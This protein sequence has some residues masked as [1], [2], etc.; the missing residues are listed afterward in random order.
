MTRRFY[1]ENYTLDIDGGCLWATDREIRLRPKTFAVLSHLVQNAGRLVTK[2][3]L[4][5]AVWP[6]IVVTDESL[7]QCVS[8]ARRA[9]GRHGRTFIRTVPRRGYRFAVPVEM[10]ATE[11]PRIGEDL[12]QARSP[13]RCNLPM[14]AVLPLVD[15]SGDQREQYLADGITDDIIT[16]LS[17]FT[18]LSVI[19]R[20]SSFQYKDKIADIRKIGME[21][22]V[23]YLLEGSIR[24]AAG[25]LRV[26][27]RLVDATTGTDLW[28]E[29]YDRELRDVFAVQDDVVG[30]IVS[31]L[32][33]HVTKAE[34]ERALQK[35][36]A[37][38]QSYD[39]Y[40]R[41]A[42]V[43][44]THVSEHRLDL[45]YD[46]RKLLERSLDIDPD[47][48]RAHA[49]LSRTF[50]RAYVEPL[51]Q[52]YLDSSALSR[53]HDLAERAVRL[54][55]NLPFARSQLGWVLSFMRRHDEAIAEFEHA[56]SLNPS[57]TDFRF[58]LGLVFAGQSERAINVLRTSLRLDPFQTPV[59]LAYL[60]HAYFML[61]RLTEAV[62]P[63]RECVARIPRFRVARVWLAATY[64]HL[65][66]IDD[67][68]NEAAQV[69]AIEPLFSIARWQ[70]T[71]PYRY[72]GQAKHLFDALCKAGLPER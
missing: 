23:R 39:Y 42:A 72:D 33:A 63:L 48:S 57:Y 14:I 31:L 24:R 7:M 43:Y 20:N 56:V 52:D 30:T 54:D 53:A 15:L 70:R 41:G 50:T 38:W 47:Y 28:A 25:H 58:G 67:A 13:G 4:I 37:D 2:S 40:L 18:E 5:D 60:G 3:D 8:E 29:R 49:M 36:P 21:L 17:R 55:P 9:L 66:Q 46:A 16:E 65:D 59:R 61:D 71:A 10:P 1:F 34:S 62:S 69:L 68:R 64:A 44:S 35:P 6:N 22:G 51:D 12:N 45:L 32:A 11:S 27:A 26:N 19:A